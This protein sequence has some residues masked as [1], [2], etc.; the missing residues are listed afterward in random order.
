MSGSP[1][2]ASLFAQR[3]VIGVGDMAVS[4]NASTVLS[5]YALGSCIG[6][7]AYDPGAKCGGI[8]HLMLPEASVSPQKAI[9]QPAMFAD[10]GLPLFFKALIGL[11]AERG[12]LKLFIAGG[13]SVIAGQDPFKIGERNIRATMDFIN[14]H[15][16]RVV[17]SDTGGSF[18]R[19]VHLELSTGDVRLVTPNGKSQLALG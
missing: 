19:T 10:T 5:T 18:N 8:L 11:K 4:N 13:A 2:I 1:T 6:V 7:I 12:R 9:T 14:T 15:A 17:Q 16:L 3:V